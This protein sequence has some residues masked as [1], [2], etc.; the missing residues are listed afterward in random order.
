MVQHRADKENTFIVSYFTPRV[1]ILL[2]FFL[3]VVYIELF[4]VQVAVVFIGGT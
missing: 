3:C 2:F 4:A 1:V